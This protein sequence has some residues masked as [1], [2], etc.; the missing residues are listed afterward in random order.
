MQDPPFR[1]RKSLLERNESGRVRGADTRPTMLDRLAVEGSASSPHLRLFSTRS[2]VLGDGELAQVVA[3]HLGLDF[4]LVELLAGVDAN[5]A[6]DHLRHHDHVAEVRFDE[7]GLL[8][9]LSTL[10][11]LPQLLDQAHGLPLQTPVDPATCS[12][13]DNISQLFG[14]EIQKSVEGFGSAIGSSPKQSPPSSLNLAT[15]SVAVLW[16]G[17]HRVDDVLVEVDASER[18]LAEGSLLLELSSLFGVLWWERRQSQKPWP[19]TSPGGQ[20]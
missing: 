8:V 11:G 20:P 12:R 18:E 19:R 15:S 2:G 14:G 9:G 5:D 6:A 3:H 1:D 17:G 13:V 4:D 10:L 16:T 7:V